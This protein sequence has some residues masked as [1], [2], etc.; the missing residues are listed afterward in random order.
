M[1]ARGWFGPTVAPHIADRI[2]DIVVAARNA[3]SIIRSAAEPIQSMM[4]GHH[5][6]LTPAEL[7]IPLCTFRS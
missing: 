5:G 2:G 1:I 3:H 7:D 4:I 6:S